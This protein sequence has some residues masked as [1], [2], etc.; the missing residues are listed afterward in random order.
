MLKKIKTL[1]SSQW[2]NSFS[3]N[4]VQDTQVLVM[5]LRT[6]NKNYGKMLQN[7]FHIFSHDSV[8]WEAHY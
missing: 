2:N 1:L 5:I 4:Y 8:L 7:S 6:T 3:E